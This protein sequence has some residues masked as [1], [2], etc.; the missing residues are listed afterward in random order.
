MS[1]DRFH[2]LLADDEDLFRDTT[3]DLLRN[4]GYAC[5]CARDSTEAAGMLAAKTY[6]VLI[7]DIKMPGN[8]HL[9]LLFETP[10]AARGL[11][12]ILVTGYPTMETALDAI[13][14]PVVA[15]LIKPVNFDELL[16]FV[17][18]A[19]A[20]CSLYRTT[21]QMRSRLQCWSAELGA[22][23]D[24]L[25][26]RSSGNLTDPAW[27]LLTAAVDMAARSL[28]DVRRI[29]ESLTLADSSTMPVET[30]RLLERLS[31]AR[32]ALH[33]AVDGL[34]ESK[35]AFKSKRLGELRRQL[36]DVLQALDEQ[37]TAK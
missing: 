12:I 30:Q 31:L 4:A 25:C 7:S 13:K 3:A 16:S 23:E 33:D 32:H 15:Y 17:R 22:M 10:V 18:V 27:T 29:I 8:G 37:P 26:E 1:D 19:V 6:D 36:Q 2:V 28:A 35:R 5:D 14:L 34:E 24:L 9:Q 20:R 11:P 21:A